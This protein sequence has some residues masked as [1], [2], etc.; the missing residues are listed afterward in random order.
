MWLTPKNNKENKKRL[1]KKNVTRQ[2]NNN[3]R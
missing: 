1:N 3:E 2:K